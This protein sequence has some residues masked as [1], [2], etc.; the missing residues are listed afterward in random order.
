MI[1]KLS[2]VERIYFLE[3]ML[4]NFSNILVKLSTIFFRNSNHNGFLELIRSN[5]KR[6]ER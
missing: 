4:S 5:E 6:G 2:I 3:F 1:E